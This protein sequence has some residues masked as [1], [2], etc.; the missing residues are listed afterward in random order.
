VAQIAPNQ[1]TVK[2]I[3]VVSTAS[4]QTQSGSVAAKSIIISGQP[5]ILQTTALQHAVQSQQTVT[6][7]IRAAPQTN[8]SP[9]TQHVSRH[10][11]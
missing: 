10:I 4:P 5:A 7:A 8:I 11:I 2:H 1:Q 3:Q 9:Q 6:F